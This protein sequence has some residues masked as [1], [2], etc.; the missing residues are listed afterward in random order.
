MNIPLSQRLRE[1]TSWLTRKIGAS[2]TPR[3]AIVLGSGFKGF[4]QRLSES[5]TIP[6]QDIPHMPVPT[7]AGHGAS[8]VIGTL[9]TE[10]IAV[11][12]GRVHLYEG[13]TEDQVVY[14][15]RLLAHLGVR[16]VLL[17][18]ASGSVDANIT[19]GSVVVITDHINFTGRSC[20]IGG[21]ARELGEIF[22]DM[23]ACYDSAWR[24]AI[25]NLG[26]VIEGVYAG[27]LGP[28]YETPAETKML[29]QWGAHV[30]GMSTIQEVIAARH[31]GVK[32]ACLSFVTNMAGGLGHHLDHQDVIRVAQSRSEALRDL[33][34]K[35]IG[36]AP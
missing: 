30:V 35:S 5:I 24:H 12:S 20:L 28:S 26:S 25:K 7:V 4:E 36:V 29:G 10:T 34:A 32:V 1:S 17:T 16:H 8:L 9:G 2:K 18:N 27:V 15:I 6:F 33:V 19:P 13:L 31:L 21:D 11:L 3:K 14:P 23:G 22:I